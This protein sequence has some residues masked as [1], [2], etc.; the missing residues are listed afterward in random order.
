[1]L[2]ELMSAP[3]AIKGIDHV[4]IRVRDVTVMK[5]FY[6]DVLGCALERANT[7]RGL[8]QL[9][10]GSALIDLV[11]VFARIGEAGGGPPGPDSHNMDH[12]CLFIEPFSEAGIRAHLAAHDVEIREFADRY[13]AKGN[14]PSVYI[15]DPEGNKVELKGRSPS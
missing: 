1:V 6:C 5:R 4:V 15:R 7:D 11:D 13:G 12:L 14:G 9:R 8:Y 10:A 3:F 2:I